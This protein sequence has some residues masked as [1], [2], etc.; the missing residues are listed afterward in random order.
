MLHSVPL[1]NLSSL[2]AGSETIEKPLVSDEL[3]IPKSL[4]LKAGLL[5]FSATIGMRVAPNAAGLLTDF[6]ALG[7]ADDREIFRYAKRFGPLGLCEKHNF[8]VLHNA[9]PCWPKRVETGVFAE[10]TT[11]WRRY[12]KR[13][14]AILSIAVAMRGDKMGALDDWQTLLSAGAKAISSSSAKHRTWLLAL[15]VNGLIENA[16]P[17]LLVYPDA[18]KDRL[19]IVFAGVSMMAGLRLL[20]QPDI[21]AT[22]DEALW[23][24]S[25]GNLLAVIALQTAMAVASHAGLAK[26]ADCGDLYRPVRALPLN[27]LHF[28]PKCGRKA[29][30]KLYMRRER[31]PELKKAYDLIQKNVPGGTQP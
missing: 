6:A 7:N 2:F 16:Q 26:C 22:K 14:N 23:L 15:A 9:Q 10:S 29:S 4:T 18:A 8:P 25:A 30:R 21:L 12:A 28:C 13:V 27:K 11:A 3:Q 19:Q 20:N 31:N 17:K 5:Q 24:P 1:M